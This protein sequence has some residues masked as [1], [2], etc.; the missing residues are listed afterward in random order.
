MSIVTIIVIA[1]GLSMDAFAIAVAS[2]VAAN[3]MTVK[4][5]FKMAAFFGGFQALMPVLGWVCGVSLRSRISAADHWIVF[6]LLTMVGLKMIWEARHE[7]ELVDRAPPGTAVLFVLALATSLDALAVGFS[8][9][10]LDVEILTPALIIGVITFLLSLGG[11]YV[12]KC[13]GHFCEKY[14]EILGGLILIGIGIKILMEHL[15]SSL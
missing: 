1:F 4:V 13:I 6:G 14:I 5:A 2:G 9:S 11:V 7:E 10:A 12:G 8:L 3:R 15:F